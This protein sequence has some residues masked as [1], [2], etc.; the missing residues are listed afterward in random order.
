MFA[1]RHP[2]VTAPPRRRRL[3]LLIVG[4]PLLIAAASGMVWLAHVNGELQSAIAEADRLDPR[5]RLDDLLADR[6]TP[7]VPN[8][9][10]KIVAADRLR[11]PQWEPLS[12]VAPLIY[13][14]DRRLTAEQ[15]AALTKAVAA[16]QPVFAVARSLIDTPHGR[17]AVTYTSS[18]YGTARPTINSSCAVAYLLEYD[19]YARIQAGD[20]DGAVQSAHA[21]FNAY[22]S[23]GDE[24]Q[25]LS[26]TNRIVGESSAIRLLERA[27]AQGEPSDAVLAAFQV[28]LTDAEAEPR[29]LYGLRGERAGWYRVFERVRDG[30]VPPSI[31]VN[32]PGTLSA[33]TVLINTP[34]MLTKNQATSLHFMT[35]LVEIVKRPPGGWTE[36]LVAQQAKIADLP[37]FVRPLGSWAVNFA[38][39]GRRHY[40]QLRCA[41][42]AVAAERFRRTTGQWPATPDELVTAGL[43][44]AVPIDPYAAG[45]RIKFA[46]RADGLTVYSVGRNGMDDGGDLTREP[47]TGETADLGFR[48]WDV[49]ARRQLPRVS[50]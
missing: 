8:S 11:P 26:Q 40:A 3:W 23:I 21:A 24:P 32:R 6:A 14:P 47:T 13:L 31:F 28:R 15:A 35:E 44:P 4:V 27:L 37:S 34:G 9:V 36:P 39:S 12:F 17:H 16:L 29:L 48:L 19:V 50:P 7:P 42:V 43:L 20:A 41:V 45:R 1:D 46:R 30:S 10:D 49:G 2:A 18:W 25:M 33:D 38:K 22:A 5:W